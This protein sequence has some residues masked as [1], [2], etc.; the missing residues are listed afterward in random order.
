MLVRIISCL[1]SGILIKESI[2][3]A[4]EVVCERLFSTDR[5]ML[6]LRQHRLNG[7]TMRLLMLLE[8]GFDEEE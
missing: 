6:G 5:N 7:E 2:L 3:P 4:S 1:N 8:N